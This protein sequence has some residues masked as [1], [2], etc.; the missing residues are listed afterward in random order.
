M[1]I[2][3]DR[4]K[5]FFVLELV[6]GGPAAEAGLRLEDRLLSINGRP[7]SDYDFDTLR[8]M[9]KREGERLELEVLR[10]EETLHISLTLRPYL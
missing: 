1:R 2:A 10:G 3:R 4:E 6:P 5:R 8:P 7:G 9:M